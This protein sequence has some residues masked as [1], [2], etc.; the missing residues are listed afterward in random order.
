MTKPLTLG[1]YD[2]QLLL[3]P[4]YDSDNTSSIFSTSFGLVIMYSSKYDTWRGIN[5]HNTSDPLG[6]NEADAICRQLG[7]T[8]A[9]S[10]SAVTQ[11]AL[12]QNYNFQ[13]C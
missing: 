5:Q 8:G 9:I 13:H 2:S 12:P 6:G 1:K 10:G 11:R 4:P 7:F 3:C